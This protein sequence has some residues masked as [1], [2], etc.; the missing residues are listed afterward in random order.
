MSTI[1]KILDGYK[2]VQEIKN[3][4]RLSAVPQTQAAAM[5]ATSTTAPNAAQAGAQA[6]AV[7]N[8]PGVMQSIMSNK[9][10]LIG[11]GVA[12]AALVLVLVMKK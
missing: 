1:D 6:S 3:I 5:S 12:V 8:Q 10:L 4:T 9:T 11:A 7:S 2:K